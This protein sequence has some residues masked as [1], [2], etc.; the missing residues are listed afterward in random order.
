MTSTADQIKDLQY[1]LARLHNYQVIHKDDKYTWFMPSTYNLFSTDYSRII[2]E[3]KQI[4]NDELTGIWN[5]NYSIF[6]KK[7]CYNKGKLERF[8]NKS[9]Y[10]YVPFDPEN[11]EEAAKIDKDRCRDEAYSILNKASHQK[12]NLSD[13]S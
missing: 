5:D 1:A 2:E 9:P 7:D 11:D 4:S 3:L 6:Q 8:I 10:F 13:D 12:H